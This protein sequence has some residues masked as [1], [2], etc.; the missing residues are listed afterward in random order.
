[1]QFS[2]SDHSLPSKIAA[3]F[4]Q[5]EQAAD[6]RSTGNPASLAASMAIFSKQSRIIAPLPVSRP[7][8]TESGRCE[9]GRA[10]PAAAAAEDARR[11]VDGLIDVEFYKARAHAIRRATMVRWAGALKQTMRAA[12]VRLRRHSRDEGK[13]DSS[14]Q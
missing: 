7:C 9:A 6:I 1:L 4:G 14:N 2:D 8:T 11:S 12:L 3:L 13:N 5:N 10:P